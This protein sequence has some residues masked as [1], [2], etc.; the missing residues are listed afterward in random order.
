[1]QRGNAVEDSSPPRMV[2]PLTWEY[3]TNAQFSELVKF[4]RSNK[5]A[6]FDD[7][8]LPN[9]VELQAVYPENQYTFSDVTKPSAGSIAWY[10]TSV[11]LPNAESDFETTEF[12]TADYTAIT[13]DD[14]SSVDTS[15]TTS[16]NVKK[17]VYHKL[18][19]DISGA[20]VAINDIQRIKFKYVGEC[21][22]ASGNDVDGVVVYVWHSNNWLRIGETTSK[23]KTT[24]DYITDEPVQAQ[25]FVDIDDQTVTVLVRSR[26][27]KGSDGNLTMKSY[28]LSLWINQD[29]GTGVI[30]SNEFT[31]DAGGDVVEVKNMTDD[32]VLT[33]NTEYV[34]GD[35]RNNLKG[36]SEDAGDLIKVTYSPRISVVSSGSATDRWWGTATPTTPPRNVSL[37]LQTLNALT[38]L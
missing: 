16:S 3:L 28:Y 33:L 22:D 30:L 21:D 20:Y 37:T 23:D 35:G 29:M 25:D 14:S 13:A 7:G 5:E 15:I 38:E 24:V 36:M 8:N 19:F 11:S 10:D 26:G 34:I 9:F 17:Y 27:H 32:N 18:Q 12:L 4:I 31:L 6:Y 2:F 1:M